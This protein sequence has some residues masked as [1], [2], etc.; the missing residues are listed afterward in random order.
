MERRALKKRSELFERTKAE[1]AKRLRPVCASS[2]DEEFQ[3]L[4]ER[5]ATVNIK[6]SQRRDI[7]LFAE[8]RHN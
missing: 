4:I 7:L 3:A 8:L 6:Y 1:I 5:I 2:P